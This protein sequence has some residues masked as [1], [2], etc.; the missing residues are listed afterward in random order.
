MPQ[1]QRKLELLVFSYLQFEQNQYW[2]GDGG[3]DFFGITNLDKCQI[4]IS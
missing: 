1:L 2:D 4:G 3:R